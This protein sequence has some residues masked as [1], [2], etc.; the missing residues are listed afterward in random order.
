MITC[1]VQDVRVRLMFLALIMNPG[2]HQSFRA[3]EIIRDGVERL[4]AGR[5]LSL[6]I[7]KSAD[8]EWIPTADTPQHR[9][10]LQVALFTAE[11]KYQMTTALA[12]RFGHG[13]RSL[14]ARTEYC[15]S[16]LLWWF[17][18]RPDETM[19]FYMSVPDKISMATV[20]GGQHWPEAR[21]M[22]LLLQSG[23]VDLHI[24]DH[25]Q[26]AAMSPA[27]AS[28]AAPAP[29]PPPPARHGGRALDTVPEGMEVS[30][31]APSAGARQASAYGSS[32]PKNS[33][34]STTR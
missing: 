25:A 32:L 18:D 21:F 19:Y 24:K 1:R 30:S 31:T 3:G 11:V 34:R 27:P 4:A 23:H 17:G 2:E 6:G 22:Q 14:S 26:Q 5:V 10:M 29:R 9:L 7:V 28:P 33:H 8:G 15:N 20:V 16:L 13:V 12:V